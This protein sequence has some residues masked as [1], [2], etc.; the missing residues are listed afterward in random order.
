MNALDE[1]MKR[2]TALPDPECSKPQSPTPRQSHNFQSYC[3]FPPPTIF[4]FFCTRDSS[5]KEIHTIQPEYHL[6]DDFERS[7]LD[8][9]GEGGGEVSGRIIHNDD[10]VCF[11]LVLLSRCAVR[12]AQCRTKFQVYLTRSYTPEKKA[13]PLQYTTQ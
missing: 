12:L 2:G 8:H 11:I 5:A 6:K 13:D 10:D 7:A 1:E 4:F 3:T 9:L